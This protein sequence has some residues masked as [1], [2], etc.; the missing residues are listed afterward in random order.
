[1]KRL[2]TP[3]RT[4]D[5]SAADDHQK[6]VDQTIAEFEKRGIECIDFEKHV[7]ETG[8]KRPDLCLPD[9]HTLVEVKTFAPQKR[10][11]EEEQRIAKELSGEQATGYWHPLFMER[12]R[13]Q[14]QTARRKFREYP[15]YHTAVLFYDLH[16]FIF[17]QTPE[18]L[19]RGQ[20]YHEYVF[21]RDNPQLTVGYRSGYKDRQLRPD[22]NQEIGAV[23]FDIGHNAFRV[24]HNH[25]TDKIRR[26]DKRI[27]NLPED[28]H[29]EY[30]DDPVS[31][32]FI[33]LDRQ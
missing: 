16:S 23:V 29:F 32:R 7:G 13:D 11:I 4:A 12:F 6:L 28:E 33:R 17:A 2:V 10:E 18:E 9:F 24:F 20:E 21:P 30:V 15:T 25:F 3:A 22:L 27:F 14:L 19:L 8:R 5:M 26:I 31:P 1:L